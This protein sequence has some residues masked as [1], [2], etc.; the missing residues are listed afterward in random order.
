MSIQGLWDCADP[1]LPHTLG[2]GLG[3]P[4]THRRGLC[5]NYLLLAVAGHSPWQVTHS[6]DYFQEL[7]DFAIDLI[8]RGLAY[9]CHQEYAEL[10][11]HNP[12]PSPWR[13]R[14]V[15]DS[16]SLFEVKKVSYDGDT[17]CPRDG[18]QASSM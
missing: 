14:P 2:T 12:P 15:E 13:N 8:K 16:L 6:S 11:G 10:R 5:L 17:D 7:Y 9:V 1:Q 18:L 4:Y 3:L